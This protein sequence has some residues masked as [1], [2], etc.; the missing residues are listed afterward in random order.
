MGVKRKSLQ[1]K[2]LAKVVRRGRG[3]VFF[4]E[5]FLDMGRADAVRQALSRL[6]RAGTIRRIT[7]ALYHYPEFND[8]LGGE[9]PPSADTVAQAIARRTDSRIVASGAL[10]AN[11]LGLST[12]VPAKRVYLTNGP[13]RDVSIGSNILSFRHASPRRMAANGK[14][15]AIV[16]EAFR[17]LKKEN[18]TNN[19]V[20]RLRR[21]LPPAAKAELHRDL[22][23]AAV[24]MR[25]LIERITG[26]EI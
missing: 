16:F 22:P 2:I 21:I 8:K 25:P 15:S 14:I 5:E 3:T 13:S 23:H 1:E 6:A 26:D 12:Q 20:T 11:L 9:L 19:V 10:A 24:W 18:V 17:Y 7:T 4:G